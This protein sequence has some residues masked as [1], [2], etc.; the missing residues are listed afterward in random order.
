[1]KTICTNKSNSFKPE[2][3]KQDQNIRAFIL[4]P[5]AMSDDVSFEAVDNG[6]LQTYQMEMLNWLGKH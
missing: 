3:A 6:N 1:M 4:L 2:I 5:L